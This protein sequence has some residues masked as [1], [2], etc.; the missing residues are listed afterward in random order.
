MPSSPAFVPEEFI[1][2]AYS[3][4]KAIAAVGSGS[5]VLD[6][7]TIS[8]DATMG[9]FQGDAATVTSQ[10]LKA[11]SGPVRFPWRFPVDSPS[12]CSRGNV[13]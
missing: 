12:I 10:V 3:H 13:S 5:Q 9:V 4:G 2:E 1:R 11:L 6:M 8:A 7:I